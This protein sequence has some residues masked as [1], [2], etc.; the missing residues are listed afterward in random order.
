MRP[1]IAGIKGFSAAMLFDETLELL[2]CEEVC[3]NAIDNVGCQE[4][5]AGLHCGIDGVHT[6]RE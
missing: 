2:L 6:I 1:R 4:E 5:P 3:S